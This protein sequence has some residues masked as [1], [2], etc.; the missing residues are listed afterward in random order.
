MRPTLWILAVLLLHPKPALAHTAPNADVQQQ[1]TAFLATFQQAINE[2]NSKPDAVVTPENQR[3]ELLATFFYTDTATVPNVL[4]P[5][6]L[7]KSIR[8]QLPVRAW[9]SQLPTF[10]WE[11]FGYELDTANAV[12]KSV[13]TIKNK[14]FVRL[15]VPVHLHGLVQATRR[16]HE[17]KEEQEFLV[18]AE[19]QGGSNRN[20]KIERI[21]GTGL[22]FPDAQ[23]TVRHLLD[24]Q[25]RLTTL[26][27]QLVFAKTAPD[28]RAEALRQLLDWMPAQADSLQF[29]LKSSSG[30]TR[31][32]SPADLT[33]LNLSAELAAACRVERFDIVHTGNFYTDRDG[34]TNGDVITLLGVSVWLDGNP[35]YRTKKTDVIRL[36]T[37]HLRPVCE[38]VRIANVL[39]SF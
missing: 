14:V 29:T 30:Q 27:M 11:G 26:V 12:L 23:L 10:F 22:G 20:W 36:A 7:Y 19:R 35:T 37:D 9:L 34:S 32:V 39:L 33:R 25:E 6:P 3:E 31:Q 24:Y 38:T 8:A 4:L 5:V 16:R 18:S 21:T 15:L 1:A 2:L 28:Q 17:F 13:Q